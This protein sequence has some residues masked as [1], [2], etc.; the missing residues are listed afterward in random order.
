[1]LPR[2]RVALAAALSIVVAGTLVS[3]VGAAPTRRAGTVNVL[4][5]MPT[6]D[7]QIAAGIN[8]ARAGYGLARLRISPALRS[9]A[10]SHSLE[11]ARDGYFSHDSADGTSAWKRLLRFYPSTGFR[12]WQAGET[13]LWYSPG[14]DAAQAVH[15][16]LTS[17]EHRAI[18][19]TP[20]YREIGVSAVHA[21]DAGGAF[22]DVETTVVT[23]DF[24]F[25]SH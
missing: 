5:A 16:W 23:A 15:D 2:T 24:G 22:G 6:L 14:V 20:A 8:A 12:R 1:V 19:L 11:M 18:L 21:T 4:T 9:A 25:R 13:L 10:R 7:T 3:T 17:P